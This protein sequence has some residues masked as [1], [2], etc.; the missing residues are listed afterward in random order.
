MISA[1]RFPWTQSMELLISILFSTFLLLSSPCDADS[2]SDLGSQCTEVEY[3][4]NLSDLLNSLV[5]NAPIQN[6]FYTTAAGKGANKIYGLTQCRGDISAT[7][8]AACIKNVTVVQGC[9]NS[10]DATLWYQ[11]CLV[12]YSDRS[13]FGELDLS[14][15]MAIH[16]DTNFEDA[17]VVS[18]GLN[19]TKKLASTTPNQ[20]SMFYTAVL[21]VGQSGKRYGMA[22]YTRD[23]S[24]SNC[25][26]CL[27][28]LVTS[29]NI[30][31]NKRSWDIS[32]SSCRM[33]YSDYQFYFNYSTPA[34]K[35]GSTRSS[36]HRVAIGVA[37][38]VLVFLL[39]L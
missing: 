20:P 1:L 28:Q 10:I 11:W 34:T 35:G 33:W 16:N 25:G 7:D 18:E 12:R 24:K 9:S 22:Q 27:F 30:I 36:P 4:A 32:G 3:Q 19:F 2:N 14:G 29:L 6:G 15:I 13:F 23:L 39:V 21:D 37:F 8:C 5:A 31:G 26:K 17:K 38:P